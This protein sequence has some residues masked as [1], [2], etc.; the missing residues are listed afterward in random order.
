[1]GG[2]FLLT[3]R[4][5]LYFAVRARLNLPPGAGSPTA[6]TNHELFGMLSA[7]VFGRPEFTG[8]GISLAQEFAAIIAG[9]KLRL[10]EVFIA[11]RADIST[12][13]AG[14]AAVIQLHL[15]VSARRTLAQ[16]AVPGMGSTPKGRVTVTTQ[17]TLD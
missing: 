16:F 8:K 3:V 2:P 12:A 15:M 13:L 17:V 1:M 9:P 5:V 6:W 11:A 7:V 4:A 10:R 14:D